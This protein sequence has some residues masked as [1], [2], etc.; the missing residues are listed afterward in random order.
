MRTKKIVAG[1]LATAMV[2]TGISIAPK[3]KVEAAVATGLVYESFDEGDVTLGTAP[4]FDGVEAGMGYSDLATYEEEGDLGE[5]LDTAEY[6]FG[7]WYYVSAEDGTAC[8]IYDEEFVDADDYSG[9]CFAKWVPASLLSVKAQNH[10]DVAEGTT[11]NIRVLSAVDCLDYQT[12][13]FSIEINNNGDE[14]DKAAAGT[15]KVYETLKAGNNTVHPSEYFGGLDS[16]MDQDLNNEYGYF[17]VWTLTGIPAKGHDDII[18]VRPYWVTADGTRV[19]GLGKY[20][21]VEDGYKGYVSVP[22]NL[23]DVLVSTVDQDGKPL[24]VAAGVV[25]ISYPDGLTLVEDKVEVGRVFSEME[26]ADKG[27]SVKFA[28]NVADIN[29]NMPANDVYVN[30]R[31]TVDGGSAAHTSYDFEIQG[32]P[33]FCDNGET[34]VEIDIWDVLY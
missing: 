29:K 26:F 9:Y 5:I 25:E 34:K 32:T 23:K 6:L 4:V 8:P 21:H 17:A 11:A 27:S 33:D 19:D 1:L 7:G 12:V 3:Q 24:G 20:V 2:I 10:K 16:A 13:G 31:F 28:A 18:Y 14:L 22:V 30:L 15:T